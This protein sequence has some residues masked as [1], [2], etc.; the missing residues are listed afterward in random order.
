MRSISRAIRPWAALLS[1]SAALNTLSPLSSLSRR[2][3]I[4]GSGA[5]ARG[6]R[7]DLRKMRESVT[8]YAISG[9]AHIAYQV[10]GDGPPI[11]FVPPFQ[12][13]V[14]LNWQNTSIAPGLRR[15]SSFA[16]VIIFDKRNTGLSDRTGR[17]PTLEERIDDTRAVM[18]SA[19]VERA[20][21]LGVSEGGPMSILFAASYPERTAGL[22]LWGSFARYGADEDPA[23]RRRF[24]HDFATVLRDVWGTGESIHLVHPDVDFTQEQ[25]ELRAHI[26]RNSVTPGG[27][28]EIIE[29]MADVDVRDVLPT[30]GA[31]ALVL[32]D[33]SDPMIPVEHGRY[34]GEHLP[35]AQYLESD[36]GRHSGWDD[37][38]IPFIDDIAEFVT[39][40]R[41]TTTTQRTLATVLFTDI[42][43]STE[44]AASIGDEAWR[45]RLARHDEVAD[46]EV[47]RFSGKIVNHTGDGILATFD[48][49]GR[50]VHCATALVAAVREHGLEIRC[51]LHTGE[52]EQGD[53]DVAGIVVHLAARVAATAGASEVLTT[54]TLRDLTIGSDL[55]Y[56]SRGEHTLKGIPD[57]W[58]ILA[59]QAST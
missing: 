34:L 1:P 57:R 59:V 47:K 18:D 5:P 33:T 12:S 48:G 15:L 6:R 35:T 25:I 16:E 27:L 46:R 30:I 42:V 37:D 26:E 13:H 54:R 58:E 14:E 2:T 40:S 50:A 3:S 20:H 11:V 29:F 52:I 7:Y 9:D 21:I 51:G 10:V 22:I 55:R 39:G 43:G 17:A 36:T 32:H 4:H 53:H 45:R 56:E 24:A 8:N 49:P 28:A 44:L 41:Q 19:E 23:A 38:D 31:P